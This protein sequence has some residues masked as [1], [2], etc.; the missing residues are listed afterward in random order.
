MS[1]VI[2]HVGEKETRKVEAKL[3][4]FPDIDDLMVFATLQ[5]QIPPEE[6]MGYLLMSKK[7]NFA[8]GRLDMMERLY[9][10]YKG[11]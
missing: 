3:V 1:I 11:K 9:A 4:N 8:I 6:A 5:F 2:N 7:Y 10:S